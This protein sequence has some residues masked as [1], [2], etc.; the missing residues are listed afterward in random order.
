[1]T[2]K[3]RDFEPS[4]QHLKYKEDVLNVQI[5]ITQLC[6]KFCDYCYFSDIQHQLN[7]KTPVIN[8]KTFH[9]II[10]FIKFNIGDR[11]LE[12][13]YF[14][15]EPTENKDLSDCIE[16]MYKA[17]PD[18][19]QTII[20]NFAKPVEYWNTIN[21]NVFI[22]ATLHIDVNPKKFVK[23]AKAIKNNV[24]TLI[25]IDNTA[26]TNITHYTSIFDNTGI[27]YY[28]RIIDSV[29][30]SKK[31]H[32]EIDALKY[33][34]S[35]SYVHFNTRK[36]FTGMQCSVGFMFTADGNVKQCNLSEPLGT[37]IGKP[38]IVDNKCTVINCDMKLNRLFPKF[39]S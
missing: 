10:E 26:D 37:F 8:S 14:G 7:T 25:L 2:L 35:I 31:Y 3:L 28:F 17:F 39:T 13:S 23:K 12:V 27:P 34:D 4:A 9:K 5:E 16:Q 32:K 29:C 11:K 30:E 22:K 20:T 21:D 33:I 19:R 38:F 1:M 36:S 15:G 18:C 24:E 6:N